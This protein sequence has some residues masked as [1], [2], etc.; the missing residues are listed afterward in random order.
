VVSGECAPF[1]SDGQSSDDTKSSPLAACFAHYRGVLNGEIITI[2]SAASDA[3][4]SESDF[5]QSKRGVFSD[6]DG[7]DVYLMPNITRGGVKPSPL[8]YL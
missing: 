5:F 6:A 8:N 3:A 4:F 1:L 2:I 7:N